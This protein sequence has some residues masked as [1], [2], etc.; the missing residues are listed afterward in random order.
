MKKK[1]FKKKL[2]KIEH[3]LRLVRGKFIGI[4]IEHTN[5][6]TQ[7]ICTIAS[8]YSANC[9]CGGYFCRA[10][11]SSP[12]LY[13][14]SYRLAEPCSTKIWICKQITAHNRTNIIRTILS[15]IQLLV[16]LDFAWCGYLS[17]HLF[18]SVAFGYWAWPL[19]CCCCCN[20]RCQLHLRLLST[21]PATDFVSP[22]SK[23]L[24]CLI[25]IAC[26]CIWFQMYRL[27]LISIKLYILYGI[28]LCS[29]CFRIEPKTP[30]RVFLCVFLSLSL[31]FTP[32]HSMHIVCPCH[33]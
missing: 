3:R 15:I 14:A 9:G 27:C 22:L 19:S 12:S 8:L 11:C 4:H 1:Y 21:I 29:C 5:L 30:T 18:D 13:R 31:P 26:Y 20:C 16:V 2:G 24:S 28:R 6:N 33:K 32:F 7:S 10:Y 25:I 23:L 17:F